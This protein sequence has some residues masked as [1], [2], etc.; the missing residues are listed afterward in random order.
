MCCFVYLS[1]AQ[2]VHAQ[3][4]TIFENCYGTPRNY[5][6]AND[7]CYASDA[8][9]YAVVGY[10]QNYKMMLPS[11]YILIIDPNG[12]LLWSETYNGPNNDRVCTA[13]SVAAYWDRYDG[14]M[15]LVTGTI[16]NEDGPDIFLVKYKWNGTSLT[17]VWEKTCLGDSSLKAAYKIARVG[18]DNHFIITGETDDNKMCLMEIYGNNGKING[19]VFKM[20]SSKIPASAGYGV[21]ELDHY[22]GN[23][24]AVCGKAVMANGNTQAF[25]IHL[26]L[27]TFKDGT[28]FVIELGPYTFGNTSCPSCECI[29]YSITKGP[30]DGWTVIA[31]KYGRSQTN[32]DY[33]FLTIDE[34]GQMDKNYTFTWGA[35]NLNEELHSIEQAFGGGYILAGRVDLDAGQYNYHYNAYLAKT[36]SSGARQWQTYLGGAQNV[37]LSLNEE[38]SFVR[39]AIRMQYIGLASGMYPGTIG[40]GDVY[41]V[42][43]AQ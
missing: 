42:K 6:S 14:E 31:G 29:G 13:Y 22:Y 25:W 40:V 12:N 32:S 4:G 26:R 19:T 16:Y 10:Q 41:V 33:W 39:T 2:N 30:Y 17:K 35:A 20:N 34:Q 36:N 38:L 9:V 11:A 5:E 15:I 24:Y 43:Y 3:G 28:R 8:G 27:S 18:N 37:G 7:I 21:V 1:G 23:N